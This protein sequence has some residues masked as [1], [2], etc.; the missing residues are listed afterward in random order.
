MGKSFKLLME[1]SGFFKSKWYFCFLKMSSFTKGL[2]QMPAGHTVHAT[3]TGV[4][5][6][7]R[8]TELGGLFTLF[9]KQSLQVTY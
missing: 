3:L 1:L 2:A 9:I 6:S 4:W 7:Q 8:I 5:S